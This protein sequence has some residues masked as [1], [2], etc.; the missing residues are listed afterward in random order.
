MTLIYRHGNS[1][2]AVDIRTRLKTDLKTAMKAKDQLAATTIRVRF[3]QNSVPWKR[4]S[5]YIYYV[6]PV[7]S[8]RSG[9]RG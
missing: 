6:L 2:N 8:R 1:E 5:R 4:N 9:K 3:P 7:R